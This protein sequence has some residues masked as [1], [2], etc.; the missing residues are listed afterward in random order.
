M[1]KDTCEAQNARSS[2]LRTWAWEYKPP[3][4]VYSV[5]GTRTRYRCECGRTFATL[6][7][8]EY[9]RG[10]KHQHTNRGNDI[11]QL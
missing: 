7:G 9:H 5:E 1:I 6:S 2:C 3:H 11:E 4:P 8:L 10:E